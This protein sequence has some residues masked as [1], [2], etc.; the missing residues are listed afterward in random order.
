MTVFKLFRVK[1][2]NMKWKIIDTIN[3]L[4]ADIMSNINFLIG[5]SDNCEIKINEEKFKSISYQVFL[6]NN[7]VF[8][9][10]NSNNIVKFKEC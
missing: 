10:N 9:K 8:L 2:N 1:N 5:S 4:E 6:E 3:N 7:F